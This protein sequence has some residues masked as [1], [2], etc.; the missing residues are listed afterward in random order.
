MRKF[1]TVYKRKVNESEKL[2]ES[3]ILGDFKK[4]Y[5]SL[6]EH[7]KLTAIHD[8]NEKSQVAFL[9][10]LGKYWSE[11]S[12]LSESGMNFLQKRET[13]LTENSTPLQKKNFLKGKAT[14]LLNETMR[15]TDLKY[16]LYT[17]IDEMYSQ[18]KGDNT[19]DVLSPTVISDIITEAFAGSLDEFILKIRT[20]LSE[21]SSDEEIDKDEEI[22]E[23]CDKDEDLNESHKP[24]VY[25][26]RKK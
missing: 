15:Q 16:K 12:G 7:Y 4:I 2:H 25:I 21:S 5:A 9:T 20:E 14:I 22:E 19:K 11:E 10:E 23:N 8:L 17:V 18:V 13:T 6:L 24:K 26:R 3:N 1:S